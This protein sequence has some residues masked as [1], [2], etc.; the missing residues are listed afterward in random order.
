MSH[1]RTVSADT[2]R[3]A[4]PSDVS[5]LTKIANAMKEMALE[6]ATL[7]D[8]VERAK[9]IRHLFERGARVYLWFLPAG[10]EITVAGKPLL[11]ESDQWKLAVARDGVFPGDVEM[12][13]FRRAFGVTGMFFTDTPQ[14]WNPHPDA[15]QPVTR[16]AFVLRWFATR[17][18]RESS[19]HKV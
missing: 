15:A 6:R 18:A 16:Y 19:L 4:L 14:Q 10:T 3:V 12:Q 2:P 13:T 5:I 9:P 1:S 11:I 17:P 8:R 7:P